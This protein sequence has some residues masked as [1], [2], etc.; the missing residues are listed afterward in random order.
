MTDEQ[1]AELLRVLSAPD[2]WWQTPLFSLL[3]LL[4]GAGLTVL[5]G[6]SERVSAARR[7]ELDERL[8]A[9]KQAP[10]WAY[11]MAGTPAMLA[12]QT[13]TAWTADSGTRVVQLSACDQTDQVA[14]WFLRQMNRL[15]AGVAVGEGM[16]QRAQIAY[17]V[18]HRL[19]LWATGQEPVDYFSPDYDDQW[20]AR[21]NAAS[22]TIR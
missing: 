22:A 13:L 6:R 9:S 19:R 15:T 11:R 4:V 8:S 18:Q 21:F 1:F 14:G 7:A 17:S 16:P 3:S 2:D 20:E 12:D 5:I 10:A